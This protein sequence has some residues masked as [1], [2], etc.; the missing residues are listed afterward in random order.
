MSEYPMTF[1]RWGE[2]GDPYPTIGVLYNWTRPSELRN[3]LMNAG[4]IARIN[5]RWLF[6]P[7]MWREYCANQLRRS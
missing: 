5:N 1:Q 7:S 6:N 4:V 3:E 2:Q